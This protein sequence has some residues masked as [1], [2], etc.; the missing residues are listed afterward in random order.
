M[1]SLLIRTL[2]RLEGLEP[3]CVCV[4]VDDYRRFPAPWWVRATDPWHVEFIARQKVRPLLGQPFDVLLVHGWEMAVAFRDLARRWPSAAVMDTVPA[5]I[6]FFR[7][8]LGFV[9]LKRSLSHQVHHR[10]FAVAAR[11]FDVFL[12][13]S[14]DCAASLEHD[15]GIAREQCFI[16]LAPQDLN[17]WKP[18]AKSAG[19]PFR[20]LFVGND[21]SRKGGHFLLRAYTEHLKDYCTLTIVS[22]DPILEGIKL[23]P[24]ARWLRGLNREQVLNAYQHSDLFLFPSQQDYA[25]QV[26]SE[27]LA[28]GLPCLVNEVD[29]ARDLVQD[30]ETGFVFSHDAPAEAWAE[31]V[32][33]LV[34]DPAKLACMSAAARRFAEENLSLARFEKLLAEVIGRLRSAQCGANSKK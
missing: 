29:G 6:D 21:F 26:L 8:R 10:A 33:Q 25:P 12:P 27:A 22:N 1:T 30:G 2:D 4:G 34:A 9:G 13:K 17:A 24:G 20:L 14:S 32:K 16:T 28:T 7:R 11:E 5:R 31:R 18:A 23:P 15:Y 19:P 3:T